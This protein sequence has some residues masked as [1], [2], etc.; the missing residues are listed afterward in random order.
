VILGT[1]GAGRSPRQRRCSD[2]GS[3][4]GGRRFEGGPNPATDDRSASTDKIC[5]PVD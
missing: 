2:S 5:H 3:D 1:R 4:S